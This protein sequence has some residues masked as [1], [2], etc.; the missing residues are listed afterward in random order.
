M[1]F[2][3]RSTIAF[4]IGNL[5]EAATAFPNGVPDALITF[6]GSVEGAEGT[7]EREEERSSRHAAPR[8]AAPESVTNVHSKPAHGLLRALP[9]P[10]PGGSSAA[11]VDATQ[12]LFAPIGSTAA[13]GARILYLTRF[14]AY[15]NGSGPGSPVTPTPR[16]FLQAV[17]QNHAGV[18]HITWVWTYE[19]PL[20]NASASAASAPQR[21]GSNGSS[22]CSRSSA[23]PAVVF[24][25][26]LPLPRTPGQGGNTA[27]VSHRS[28]GAAAPAAGVSPSDF[29][30]QLT[31][32][33][34]S[35]ITYANG[36]AAASGVG[37]S[38]YLGGD[39]VT[40]ALSCQGA[41][42]LFAVKV[43]EE[44][45]P[46]SS[47][48]PASGLSAAAADAEPQQPGTD[49]WQQAWAAGAAGSGPLHGP[50][51]GLYRSFPAASRGL[52]GASDCGS[53]PCLQWV[54]SWNSTGAT[55]AGP[56][57][58][59][60]VR[61]LGALRS[62]SST[63]TA[64]IDSTTR[65]VADSADVLI[66]LAVDPTSNGIAGS[67]VN[68]SAGGAS[69]A[70]VADLWTAS[71]ATGTLQLLQG[72]SGATLF[73]TTLDALM[74]P[75]AVSSGAARG[76][77]VIANAA[78]PSSD[79][80]VVHVTPNP[81]WM[82]FS[83]AAV[84]AQPCNAS[85]PGSGCASSV[86]V[87][88]LQLQ[89]AE[90]DH[91]VSDLRWPAAAD[92]QDL[93]LSCLSA[94]AAQRSAAATGSSATCGGPSLR[95]AVAGFQLTRQLTSSGARPLR[96]TGDDASGVSLQPLW[97]VLTPAADAADEGC[98]PVVG[99][100]AVPAVAAAAG[101]ARAVTSPSVVMAMTSQGLA[102]AVGATGV[103]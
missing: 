101:S 57:N 25:D 103:R 51:D 44:P 43:S 63:A 46:L 36:S 80:G 98:Y 72:G 14:Y 27:S 9:A 19:L 102:F 88:G 30:E 17:D 94:L 82:L 49:A 54:R 45:A 6:T 68:G 21:G 26:C 7:L 60:T 15:V 92:D 39:V 97:C 11:G 74:L 93:L 85:A 28:K 48:L 95:Y 64:D 31:L 66:G 87:V 83:R 29:I 55:T 52:S 32:A 86:V 62:R 12:G 23:A 8:G 61:P 42:A 58:P 24:S 53:A 79:G 10:A 76:A 90:E 33:G 3:N 38:V 84:S 56:T 40:L 37:G 91:A 69:A 99:Q 5:A 73:E 13:A 41:T 71:L 100:P 59:N 70:G 20:G 22:V 77:G 16:L 35:I 65:G 78:A 67:A 2:T 96:K 50:V 18:P 81:G 4:G 75:T 47:V 34:P 89:L 1:T